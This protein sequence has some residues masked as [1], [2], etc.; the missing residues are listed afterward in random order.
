[1]TIDLADV[2]AHVQRLVLVVK[3][4]TVLEEYITEKQRFVGWGGIKGLNAIFIKKCFLFT[5][6][7]VCRVKPFTAWWQTFR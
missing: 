3:M 7:N 2:H 1:M 5:V 6:R 4:V